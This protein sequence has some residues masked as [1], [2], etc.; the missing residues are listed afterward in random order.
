MVK[1]PREIDNQTFLVSRYIHYTDS[2]RV[3]SKSIGPIFCNLTVSDWFHPPTGEVTW[4]GSMLIPMTETIM[5]GDNHTLSNLMVFHCNRPSQSRDR[6]LQSMALNV[7]L[8]Q[9][10]SWSDGQV[11]TLFRFSNFLCSCNSPWARFW[12]ILKK[13]D[14]A[15]FLQSFKEC[16]IKRKIYMISCLFYLFRSDGQVPPWNW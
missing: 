11:P 15:V 1:F 7:T 4:P 8:A 14:C 9:N 13:I 16:C 5:N 10:E 12:A 2:K 6:R 3:L